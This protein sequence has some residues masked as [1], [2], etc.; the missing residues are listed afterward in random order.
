MRWSGY[1]SGDDEDDTP[2]SQVVTD[3]ERLRHYDLYPQGTP[4]VR[5]LVIAPR[6]AFEQHLQTQI[7]ELKDDVTSLK[8]SR[9]FWKWVAG[10]GLPGLLSVGFVLLLRNADQIA[11]S[12]ERV[13]EQ[14]AEI[15]ALQEEVHNLRV[16]IDKLA[17]A[18]S[19]SPSGDSRDMF[20][21]KLS[22]NL[23]GPAC[24]FASPS[25]FF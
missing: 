9:S 7:E 1:M 13:G 4:S 2:R 23:R 21:D 20:P 15:R 25:L 8:A 22:L 3:S 17:G 12:A 10:L 24:A 14:R 5:E 16:K 18:D 6:N 19:T 11:A